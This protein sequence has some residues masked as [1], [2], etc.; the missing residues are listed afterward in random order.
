MKRL[1]AAVTVSLT[2]S[3][4]SYFSPQSMDLTGSDLFKFQ[5]TQAG[6]CYPANGIDSKE[7]RAALNKGCLMF[8]IFISN[9]SDISQSVKGKVLVQ[10]ND[11][12]W[13][14]PTCDHNDLDPFCEEA[15]V[16]TWID[17][18]DDFSKTFRLNTE[19]GTRFIKR[20][21]EDKEL[22][23]NKLWLMGV[24]EMTMP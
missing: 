15:Y 16:D 14:M 12:K 17:P 19:S 8:K 4:C 5:A 21:L 2:L 18:F 3:G 24:V 22:G 20:A 13:Y 23:N 6:E 9:R 7:Q 10:S 11:G 1:L